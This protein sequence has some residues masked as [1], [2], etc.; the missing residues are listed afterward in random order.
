MKLSPINPRKSAA[1]RLGYKAELDATKAFKFSLKNKAAKTANNPVLII[2]TKALETIDPTKLFFLNNFI[3]NPLITPAKVVFKIQV[4]IVPTGL[5]A[6][7]IEIVLGERITITP[8]TR[9]R[10]P[11]TIGPYKIAP[12]AIGIND[13]LIFEK[14]G[15]M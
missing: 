1:A 4:T 3:T 2:G 5:T 9:P 15:L 10:N 14:D 12:R 6:K 13:R 7:K 11:P 8:Q